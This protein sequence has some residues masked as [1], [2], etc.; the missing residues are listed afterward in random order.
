MS[1]DCVGT[2]LILTGQQST[3]MESMQE[4]EEL[5][6]QAEMVAD[7]V[8]EVGEKFIFFRIFSSS[9]ITS[10]SLVCVLFNFQQPLKR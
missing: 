6:P 2:E 8:L 1:K 4:A 7:T 5:G 10:T 3:D 9:Q